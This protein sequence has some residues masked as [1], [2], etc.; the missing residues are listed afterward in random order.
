MNKM[1]TDKPIRKDSVKLLTLILDCKL[2]P[3]MVDVFIC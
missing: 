3:A 1:Q 2:S